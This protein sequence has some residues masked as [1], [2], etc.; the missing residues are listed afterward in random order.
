MDYEIKVGDKIKNNDKRNPD[1]VREINVVSKEHVGYHSG[2]RQ[3]Y[4]SR[5][6]VFIDGKKRSWGWNV[7]R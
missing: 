6:R 5:T 4:V 1:D 2:A 7:L 3:C